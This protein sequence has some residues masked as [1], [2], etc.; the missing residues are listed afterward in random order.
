MALRA[1]LPLLALLLVAAP[2]ASAHTAVYSAD[3]NVRASVGLLNEPVSTYAVTGL[4]VCFSENTAS[5]PRP[6]VPVANPGAFTAT[7]T[8]PDGT[9]HTADL[10]VPFGNPNC[11]TF[12]DP[13]VLTQPGQYLVS[14]SGSINGTT[15]SA[16]GVKAGGEVLDRAVLTF[17]DE[18]IASNLDLMAEIAALEAR[19]AQ[20]EADQAEEESQF[21][22]GAPLASVVLLLAA[23]VALRRRV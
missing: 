5:T 2:L 23:V 22:P 10:E 19:L 3:G 8:A 11:L 20:L 21:A 12:A 16:T 15:F 4:D 14:L 9:V 7:L 13:L 6:P 17:P 1:V 18:G